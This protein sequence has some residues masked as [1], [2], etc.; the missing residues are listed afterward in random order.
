MEKYLADTRVVPSGRHALPTCNARSRIADCRA[1][2]AVPINSSKDI[3]PVFQ[4]CMI[5]SDRYGRC[6]K[7]Q[8]EE[9]M[10][11]GVLEKGSMVRVLLL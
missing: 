11:K 3:S 7:F 10:R 6:R 2:Y 8:P 5:R 1:P 9:L 4:Y